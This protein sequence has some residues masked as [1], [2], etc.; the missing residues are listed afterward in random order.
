MNTVIA[1]TFSN[2]DNMT[3]HFYKVENVHQNKIAHTDELLNTPFALQA[4]LEEYFQMIVLKLKKN[5]VQACT[6]ITNALGNSTAMHGIPT[7]KDCALN[8]SASEEG[9]SCVSHQQPWFHCIENMHYKH[10][11]SKRETTLASFREW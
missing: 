5:I 9:L 4:L 2:K 6:V 10:T 8:V 1:V 3:T 7:R 11:A